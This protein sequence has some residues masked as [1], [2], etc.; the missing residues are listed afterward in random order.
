MMV[1]NLLWNFYFWL[2]TIAI[3]LILIEAAKARK[4]AW[5]S[6]YTMEDIFWFLFNGLAFGFIFSWV[7]AF[8][9]PNVFYAYSSQ[10]QGTTAF[11]ALSALPFWAQFIALLLVQDLI[12]WSIHY[13]LHRIPFLWQIHKLHH[14]IER[15]NWFG[16]FRF[17]WLEILVY[18]TIKY[19][20]LLILAPS[21][22]IAFM[23]GIVGVLVGSLN[24]LSIPF[25]WQPTA[26]GY[27]L[28]SPGF[29]IWHHNASKDAVNYAIIFTFWDYLFHTA[30]TPHRGG[31]PDKIGLSDS[32]E[33]PKDL[34]RR[35]FYPLT[36]FFKA[37]GMT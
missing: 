6:L 3:M 13:A 5:L 30:Y 1:T 12:E 19:V 27:I 9:A 22:Q 8:I 28:N 33:Y 16:N 14:S 35:F 23:V 4:S 15:M 17:H 7:F 2:F 36:K 32:V 37:P 11:L 25:T 29:H 20:P 31:L 26:V 10:L 34:T 18:K 21:Y 24:H